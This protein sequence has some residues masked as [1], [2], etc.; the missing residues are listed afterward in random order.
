MKYLLFLFL[1][2]S[3][4]S[5]ESIWIPFDKALLE[6]KKDKKPLFVE[7]FADWCVPCQVMEA[8]V[9]SDSSVQTT[10]TKNFHAVR[11]NVE[12]EEVIF[13]EGQ[14]LPVKECY[15]EKLQLRGIPSFVILD[16]NGMSLLSLSGAMGTEGMLRFLNKVL[17]KGF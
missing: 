15:T 2:V 16:S 8:N 4:F 1:A 5:A 3:V 12:S 9:F 6:A 11:L 10:I 13:C 7:Y 14:K 17:Y